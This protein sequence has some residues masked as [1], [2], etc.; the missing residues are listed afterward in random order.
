[1]IVGAGALAPFLARADASGRAYQEIVIWNHRPDAARR[2]SAALVARGLPARAVEDL[3]HRA[4]E[5]RDRHKR[6][7]R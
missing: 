6:R 5:R 3:R 2:A 4:R 1:L 7:R